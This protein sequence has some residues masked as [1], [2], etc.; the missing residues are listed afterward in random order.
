[1]FP[2]P[3][4]QSLSRQANNTYTLYG[5]TPY[6]DITNLVADSPANMVC[7]VYLSTALATDIA[8][9]TRLKSDTDPTSCDGLQARK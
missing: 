9:F 6:M 7:L 2:P 1:M 4:K 3:S 5:H 8:C